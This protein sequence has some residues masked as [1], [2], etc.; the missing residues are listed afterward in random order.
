VNQS[1]PFTRSDLRELGYVLERGD[2]VV[3]MREIA[4]G[5]L[6]P[7]VIGLRHDVDNT[8][9]ASLELARW[10]QRHGF[11]ATYY[12]LHDSPYWDS[13]E[14]R[15]TLAAI[16]ELGHEIGIH[17]N[18]LAVALRT[19]REPYEVLASALAR[20]RAWGFTVTGHVAH[21]DG[22]WCYAQDHSL[23]FVNDE[24][25]EECARPELGEP[26]RVI[27]ARGRTLRLAPISM[28][29]FGLTYDAYRVGARALYLS[30]SGGRWNEDPARIA[31]QFPHP[32]GQLHILVHPCWWTE[33]FPAKVAV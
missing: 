13:E 1:A 5:E 29:E 30:D 17:S 2:E 11:R 28:S 25:L 33:A 12:V 4:A 15:P 9:A 31:A 7:N 27:E 32:T 21:G 22:E 18:A 6:H 24:L 3:A 23:V 26:D 20:L 10:E 14:L 8:L 16:E 19:G